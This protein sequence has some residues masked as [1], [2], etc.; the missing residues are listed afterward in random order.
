MNHQSNCNIIGY[1]CCILLLLF[2]DPASS[3]S[4]PY[5]RCDVLSQHPS[6]P[7]IKISNLTKGR[8]WEE[9]DNR[10]QWYEMNTDAHTLAVAKP[11]SIYS[12]RPKAKSSEGLVWEISDASWKNQRKVSRR[13]CGTWRHCKIAAIV[14]EIETDFIWLQLTPC[15]WQLHLTSFDCMLQ[16]RSAPNPF[17]LHGKLWIS[18]DHS[19]SLDP[20]WSKARSTSESCQLSLYWW[21]SYFNWNIYMIFQMYFDIFNSD[22]SLNFVTFR[23][24]S[25]HVDTFG[26]RTNPE[27]ILCKCVP[28][29]ANLCADLCWPVSINSRAPQRLRS[30]PGELH[31]ERLGIWMKDA[32]TSI[33]HEEPVKNPLDWGWQH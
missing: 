1:N 21:F 18:L 12:S 27:T 30:V 13:Q 5:W 20:F 10:R 26:T 7:W 16:L 31:G 6:E 4:Q 33:L 28:T 17:T 32:K 29:R 2:S 23:Y 8:R 19:R 22:D 3:A 14:I 24:I 11:Y 9:R 15:Y 25:T